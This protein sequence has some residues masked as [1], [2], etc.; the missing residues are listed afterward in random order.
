M[1]YYFSLVFF[2]ASDFC[3]ENLELYHVW[4]TG[5]YTGILCSAVQRRNRCQLKRMGFRETSF[6][7]KTK[8]ITYLELGSWWVNVRNRSCTFQVPI[9]GDGCQKLLMDWQDWSILGAVASVHWVLFVGQTWQHSGKA[10]FLNQTTTKA[11]L[12]TC[13]FST[14]EH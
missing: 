11:N 3:T 13:L 1:L 8:P 7:N 5:E 4:V 2:K 12:T 10:G 6:G 14:N 9:D